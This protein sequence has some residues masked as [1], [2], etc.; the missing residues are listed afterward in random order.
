MDSGAW[1]ATVHWVAKELATKWL[2]NYTTTT[3]NNPEVPTWKFGVQIHIWSYATLL[4]ILISS[5]MISG[6]LTDLVR[7]EHL[8]KMVLLIPTP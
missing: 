7:P 8:C 2:S 3:T 5:Y 6:K 4:V 1:Q